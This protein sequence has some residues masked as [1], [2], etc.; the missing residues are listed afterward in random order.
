[1]NTITYTIIMYMLD[2]NSGMLL[3]Y[4]Y[5]F[6]I[7]LLFMHTCTVP[8]GL[9][10]DK[11]NPRCEVRQCCDRNEDGEYVC[12]CLQA[13]ANSP[14]E[15]IKRPCESMSL[16]VACTGG[17]VSWDTYPLP[18]YWP[19]VTVHKCYVVIILFFMMAYPQSSNIHSI[20][21]PNKR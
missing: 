11:C 18:K 4:I 3:L 1:M 21:P 2:K 6:C 15:Y 17:G 12:F 8:N 10:T 7:T 14:D 5:D 16:I 19:S 20:H 9:N 13:K